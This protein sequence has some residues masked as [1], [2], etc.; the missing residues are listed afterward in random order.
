MQAGKRTIGA[1]SRLMRFIAWL[2][3]IDAPVLVQ[4]M[5]VRQRGIKPFAVMLV[6]LL[7]LSDWMLG[8]TGVF[9]IGCTLLFRFASTARFAGLR[10]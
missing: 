7:I 1:V 2:K 10:R 3:R 8:A 6:Y 4:E 9:S 5:R